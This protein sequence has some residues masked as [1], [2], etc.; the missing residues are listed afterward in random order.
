MAEDNKKSA[1]ILITAE[2][3]FGKY[4]GFVYRLYEKLN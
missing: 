4:K 2:N 1:E 3:T